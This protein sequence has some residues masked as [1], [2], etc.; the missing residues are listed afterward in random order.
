[1]RQIDPTLLAIFETEQREIVERLRTL[2][3]ALASSSSPAA[4][5]E[6]LRRT[7]TL[8]GAARAVGLGT[9]EGIAHRLETLL[10][11][12][13]D[14]GNVMGEPARTAVECGLDAVEDVLARVMAGETEP[15]GAATLVAIERALS[16]AGETARKAPAQEEE[17]APSSQAAPPAAEAAPEMVRL[18]AR[19]LDELVR[20]SSRILA[21]AGH[22]G[23][24]PELQELDGRLRELASE[25]ARLRQQTG[26]SEMREALEAVASEAAALATRARSAVLA[27]RRR[28]WTLQHLASELHEETCAARMIPADEVFGSFRKMVRELARDQAKEVEFQFEG[29]SVQADRLVLQQLKEPVMHLLRNAITH[30]IEGPDRRRAG[31]K[32]SA[33]AVRLVLEARGDRLEVRVEDDGPGI[34]LER[35]RDA[36]ASRGLTGSEERASRPQEVFHLLLQPGFSTAETLTEFAGRGMGLTIVQRAVAALHGELSLDESAGTSIVLSVPLTISTHHVLLVKCGH[37]IFGIPAAAVEKLCRVRPEGVFPLDGGEAVLVGGQPVPVAR[38]A[39]VLGVAGSVMEPGARPVVVLRVGA[40]RAGF[41]VDRLV[42]ERRAVVKDLGLMPVSA[43]FSTGGVPLEDGGVAVVLN[44]VLLLERWRGAASAPPVA[45]E[46][47]RPEPARI[48]VVDDSLTTR[49]LEK[50][51][52]EAHGYRVRVAVDGVEA[53]AALRREK[54]DLVIADLVMPRMDGFGLLEK[55]KQDPRLARIPVIIV[56]S[57]EKRE[58]Q[59]RGLSLGADA[60]IVKR[61]FDQKELL[62]TIRQIL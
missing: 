19:R 47:A 61:K 10:I 20:Y 59:E 31:G 60:Y 42:D 26:A 49:S 8:K 36:A 2:L 38:L 35:V 11:R 32:P 29:S 46:P 18:R 22:P 16:G 27:Q 53:L 41:L 15:D 33:G 51:I 13:R 21:A 39:A 52:L 62:E 5:E 7:H 43:G 56:S 55:I 48:L 44:P 30:G 50:S 37:Q 1:M 14:S 45:P 9:T 3:E 12:V 58:D 40:Q 54:A 24:L 17:A 23:A 34:D 4:M 57:L 28:S 25:C 6:A